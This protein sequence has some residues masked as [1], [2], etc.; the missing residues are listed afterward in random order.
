LRYAWKTGG[1]KGATGRPVPLLT[2]YLWIAAN[3]TLSRDPS[4]FY[5]FSRSRNNAVVCVPLA[6]KI[7]R[8]GHRVYI[9]TG[10]TRKGAGIG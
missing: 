7:Y 9:H 10:Q 2:Q 8:L 6:E 3:R 4:D 1:E 5:I